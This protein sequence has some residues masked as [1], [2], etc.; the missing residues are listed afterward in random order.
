TPS[1]VMAARG[2]AAAGLPLPRPRRVGSTERLQRLRHA[3]PLRLFHGTLHQGSVRAAQSRPAL[4]PVS[5][6]ASRYGA[7][8]AA[9]GGRTNQRARA[10]EDSFD[11]TALGARSKELRMLS[12]TARHKL[13]S[14]GA[15]AR[16]LESR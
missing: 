3:R 7:S 5:A 4:P 11:V 16:R 8:R 9:V 1:A 2:Q 15:S 13:D 14:L 6:G 12:C 10:A